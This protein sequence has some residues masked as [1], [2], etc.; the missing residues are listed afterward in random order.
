MVELVAAVL[1]VY[2][3]IKSVPERWAL[4]QPSLSAVPY[5]R[6]G[7]LQPRDR[8]DDGI[9]IEGDKMRMPSN[10]NSRWRNNC[11]QAISLVGEGKFSVGGEPTTANEVWKGRS[12]TTRGVWIE[13]A[14]LGWGWGF[15]M[16]G[17]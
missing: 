14:L 17:F 13:S 8:Q 7:N 2:D 5:A 1:I 3:G 16:V 11:S 15:Q 10:A 6:R 9:W 4:G 12:G